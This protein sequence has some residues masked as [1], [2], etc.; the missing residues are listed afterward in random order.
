MHPSRGH[1][2]HI[3]SYYDVQSAHTLYIQYG[4]YIHTI[5]RAK[6][7]IRHLSTHPRAHADTQPLTHGHVYSISGWRKCWFWVIS[8]SIT[9]VGKR[10]L[11]LQNRLRFAEKE[12]NCVML[13]VRYV[14]TWGH[15]AVVPMTWTR[16]MK[17]VVGH[18]VIQLLLLP[19]SFWMDR[20]NERENH[21]LRNYTQ[22]NRQLRN[23]TQPLW[24]QLLI[25]RN[26][27]SY[28]MVFGK[29]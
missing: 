15:F 27:L 26:R 2:M 23:Y 20:A 8:I 14:I 21:Q 19:R 10:L 13:Y 12:K 24:A 11:I 22:L 7:N 5:Q 9:L 18:L 17:Y 29:P 4:T 1:I 25:W 6:Y 28:P 16:Q 3:H